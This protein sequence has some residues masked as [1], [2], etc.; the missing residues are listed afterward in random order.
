M[1][2]KLWESFPRLLEQNINGLLDHAGPNMHKA[3]FIYKACKRE[4]LWDGDYHDFEIKIQN[5]YRRTKTDRRKA[6]LDNFLKRPMDHDVYEVF[7]LDFRSAEISDQEVMQLADWTHNMLRIGKKTDSPVIS[8]S[9]LLKTL[10]RITNP[11][12]GEKAYDIKF[13]DFTEAWKK[14]VFQEFGQ[15][16]QNLMGKIVNDLQLMNERLKLQDSMKPKVQLEA[17]D[18]DDIDWLLALREAAFNYEPAPMGPENPKASLQ[19]VVRLVSL[20]K[21]VQSTRLGELRA[22][23]EKIRLSL[24][25]R[26]DHLLRIYCDR[27]A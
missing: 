6:H 19:E 3:Y 27:A 13:E 15:K 16:H 9:I 17:L 5:Y 4:D 11:G 21:I 10:Q 12:P 23:R 22:H 14:S 26:C 2:A 20:Y 18:S 8:K 1:L 24:M 7:H 25:D